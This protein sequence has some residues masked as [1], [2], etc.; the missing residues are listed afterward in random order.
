[1]PRFLTRLPNVQLGLGQAMMLARNAVGL[2]RASSGQGGLRLPA[3]ENDPGGAGEEAWGRFVR[4]RQP[5]RC[6]AE[7]QKSKNR[8]DSLSGLGLT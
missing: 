8:P 7:G 3:R 5:E 6:R 1:M 2:Q 4:M